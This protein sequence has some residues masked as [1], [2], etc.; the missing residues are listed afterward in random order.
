MAGATAPAF[1]WLA[2]RFRAQVRQWLPL[3]H[4][5]IK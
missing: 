3:L 5:L 1:F 4:H 2:L